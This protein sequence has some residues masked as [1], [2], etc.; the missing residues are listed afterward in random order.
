VQKVR[1][2]QELR[3][4]HA[5]IGFFRHREAP[6]H[7]HRPFIS[8]TRGAEYAESLTVSHP[9][10]IESESPFHRAGTA[11]GALRDCFLG[12]VF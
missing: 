9:G 1:S 11:H 8:L 3:D 7:F 6:E 2:C 5:F 4:G 10:G 12:L